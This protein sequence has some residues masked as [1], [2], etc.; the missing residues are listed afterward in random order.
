M[1]DLEYQLERPL[2][3][4]KKRRG[5]KR[6][7]PTE[8]ELRTAILDRADEFSILTGM[9]V[10]VISHLIMGERGLLARIAKGSNFSVQTYGKIMQWFDENW[11][12]G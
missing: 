12:K 3:V 9:S 6:K 1:S 5:R 4:P 8:M 10:S 11:P 2:G 7:Y